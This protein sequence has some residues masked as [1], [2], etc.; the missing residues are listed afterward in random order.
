MRTSSIRSGPG[1]SFQGCNDVIDLEVIVLKKDTLTDIG[2]SKRVVSFYEEPGEKNT[3]DV[4]STL[5]RRAKEGG[6]EAVVVA[7]I[8]GR[9]AVRIAEILRRRRLQTKVV[10][11]S[12]PSS[13]ERWPQ[14]KFP[15][16]S[17]SE[18]RLLESLRVEIV[19]RTEEP[20]KPITFRDWWEGKTLVV[21]RPESDLF[22]MTLICVGGHG[23]RT[24][25]GVVFMAVEAGA[26]KPGQRIIGTAGTNRGLD[27]AVVLRACRFEDAV[28]HHPTK[29]L[30]VEE[31]LAMPKQTTWRGYG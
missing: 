9:T 26:I 27:S 23:F 7:S 2:T 31:I 24:A 21:P 5:T 1:G 6:I 17:K 4:I 8:S 29:R 18:R 10:C 28:G 22:W 25:I 16:I 11:V 14:Y 30:K 3:D 12:G 15:L 19:D 20:F 13:W